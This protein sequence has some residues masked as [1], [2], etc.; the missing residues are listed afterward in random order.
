[1][2][3]HN[4]SAGHPKIGRHNRGAR[5]PPAAVAKN[6][7]ATKSRLLGFAAA[8]LVGMAISSPAMAS[9][10]DYTVPISK[11]LM[12]GSESIGGIDSPIVFTARV[13]RTRLVP[14]CGQPTGY[15]GEPAVYGGDSGSLT[16]GDVTARSDRDGTIAVVQS[17]HVFFLHAQYPN[18]GALLNG[19]TPVMSEILFAEYSNSPM[20]N[21]PE[22]PLQADF[23]GY[24]FGFAWLFF[25]PLVSDPEYAAGNYP[26]FGGFLLPEDIV[27][28]V[29]VVPEPGTLGIICL[30]LGVIVAM[31]RHKGLG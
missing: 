23:A 10:I 18:Y 16:I 9:R 19:R 15:V 29:R 28:K 6:D 24:T 8:A 20:F 22:L 27:V 21:G 4:E 12:H 13:D 25:R 26:Q 1:M 5:V 14:C 30:G 11:E 31:R 7:K 2:R 3:P 17:N